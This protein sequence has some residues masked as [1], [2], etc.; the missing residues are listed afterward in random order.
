MNPSGGEFV[1]H[2]RWLNGTTPALTSQTMVGPV[3][4]AE[5]TETVSNV[6][7]YT[8]SAVPSGITASVGVY[9]I[10]PVTQNATLLASSATSSNP[11]ANTAV[12][13]A[14]LSSFTK[15]AGNYYWV[16]ILEVGTT[17]NTFAGWVSSTSTIAPAALNVWPA[18]N[19]SLAAQATLP[20]SVLGTTLG[21]GTN[22]AT[23][24]PIF[25]LS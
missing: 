14:L 9:Q 12:T 21:N 25:R 18:T 6:T 8:G 5:K 16:A 24:T 22:S 4:K 1:P 13:F 10:D 20:A 11:A 17:P 19:Y 7:V 15:V 3:F 2:R 23:A